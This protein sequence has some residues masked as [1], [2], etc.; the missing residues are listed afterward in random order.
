VSGSVAA[1]GAGTVAVIGLGFSIG[2]SPTLYDLTLRTL[3]RDRQPVRELAA[4]C[5]GV[6]VATL[7]LLAVFR[8]LDPE[9]IIAA[10]EGRLDALLV[11]ATADLLAGVL[12]LVAAAVVA[13]RRRR[14]RSARPARP[15]RA[16]GPGRHFALGFVGVLGVS[17]LATSYLADRTI[18]AMTSDLA[19]RVGEYALL[20]LFAVGPYVLVALLWERVPAVPAIAHRMRAAIARV[21]L[22]LV[23]VI[24]LA[25]A[26]LA[27]ITVG[28]FGHHLVD[29]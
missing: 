11:S 19:V 26:G 7:T 9:S 23:L 13:I 18:S 1:V 22:R 12:L 17:S 4:L 14:P 10:F 29:H 21:D 25:L 15:Q 28:T 2:F 27:S 8:T 6:L 24:G 3:T 16:T 5:G 20:C